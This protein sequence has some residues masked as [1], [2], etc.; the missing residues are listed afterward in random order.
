MN[1]LILAMKEKILDFL[2][3][4]LTIVAAITAVSLLLF[5][6]ASAITIGIGAAWVMFNRIDR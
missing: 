2:W 5:D 1:D 6:D 3:H 4:P